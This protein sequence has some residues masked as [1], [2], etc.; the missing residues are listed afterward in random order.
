MK[1][2]LTKPLS[3]ASAVGGNLT[4]LGFSVMHLTSHVCI[5]VFLCL[6]EWKMQLKQISTEIFCLKEIHN[7]RSL[8]SN[9]N[10]EISQI[11]NPN[12]KNIARSSNKI[13]IKF[14]YVHA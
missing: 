7:Q 8:K 12:F 1:F 13:F 4:F 2:E 3:R 9:H 14:N 5:K 10:Q 6:N 11:E